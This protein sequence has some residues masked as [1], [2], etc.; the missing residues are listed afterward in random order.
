TSKFL[1]HSYARENQQQAAAP[2]TAAAA[3]AAAVGFVAPSPSEQLLS[4]LTIVRNMI[5]DRRDRPRRASFLLAKQ[6][7]QPKQE[8]TLILLHSSLC[9]S[10]PLLPVWLFVRIFFSP[11]GKR[12][13]FFILPMHMNN[14][15]LW[16]HQRGEE[17]GHGMASGGG[18]GGGGTPSSSMLPH[19]GYH[20]PS[21]EQGGSAT[22]AASALI[23]P[24]HGGAAFMATMSPSATAQAG[25][26][27]ATATPPGAAAYTRSQQQFSG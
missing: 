23:S 19:G 18:G 7:P 22:V 4:C 8:S 16:P 25:A 24:S 14:P 6:G 2:A 20:Q 5:H 3:A 12:Q 27:S 26:S 10:L 21:A 13:T 15:V 11:A 17:D 1:T 9:R